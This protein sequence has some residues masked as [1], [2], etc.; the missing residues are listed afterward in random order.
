MSCCPADVKVIT[1]STVDDSVISVFIDA[2]ACIMGRVSACT[3]A[4]GVSAA[5]IDQATAF[6]AAHLL[7]TSSVGVDSAVVTKERFENWSIERAVGSYSGTGVLATPYG[8]SAN[9]ITG[10]CLKE[11][12]KTPMQVCFFG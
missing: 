7:T 8:A 11:A 4:R 10:G 6:L 3:T 2:A 9:A 5:C 1:G 12:D